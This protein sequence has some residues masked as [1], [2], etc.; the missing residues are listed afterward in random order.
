MGGNVRGMTAE[1][2]IRVDLSEINGLEI[3]C[4]CGAGIVLPALRENGD[5]YPPRVMCQCPVC[6]KTL[7]EGANDP[8]FAPIV[9]FLR[10]I[11]WLKRQQK[12]EAESR[13]NFS[14]SITV[15]SSQ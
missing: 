11:G 10:A 14:L 8:K 13:P 2:N 12:L 7:W 9:S 5:L 15:H 3:T 6:E 1:K 4:K